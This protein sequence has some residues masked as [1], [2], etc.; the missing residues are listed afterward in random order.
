[1]KNIF[2]MMFVASAFIGCS[3]TTNRCENGELSQAECCASDSKY[4]GN[5]AGTDTATDAGADVEVDTAPDADATCVPACTTGV[6]DTNTKTCVG[7]AGDGDCSAAKPF[8]DPNANM[9]VGCVD[10]G[11]CS[12][13]TSVCDTT[14]KTCV[15]CVGAQGCAA[16]EV[17][18]P[19][20]TCV[21]CLG[22][23]DC[24]GDVCDMA[25]NTC[26]SCL[27]DND[28]TDGVCEPGVTSATN[29]CVACRD[30]TTCTTV[31][32]SKCEVG[33]NE[34]VAC[35]DVADC[36]H[37]PNATKYCD[38]GLCAGCHLK[39]EAVDCGQF[40]CDGSTNA[41]SSTMAGNA[42]TCAPCTANADCAIGYR[43]VPTDFGGSS[44]GNYCVQL[45]DGTTCPSPYN[46][47]ESIRVDA[48]GSSV[49]VCMITESIISCA[50]ITQYGEIC[51]TS[52]ATCDA[53][54]G[55]VCKQFGGATRA[56]TYECSTNSD[57]PNG[58]TC[59]SIAGGKFCGATGP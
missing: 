47:I 6:C 59:K 25:T 26:V 3:D 29:E 12:G 36:S 43:C 18:S 7:C 16:N 30:N 28:C 49:D 4:C 39:S 13:D 11:N 21:G 55:S 38:A 52:P 5:D 24:D 41:C 48:S 46:I 57:C 45:Y 10:N 50:A 19:T 33:T 23:G 9:C 56:C 1:M 40:F 58:I 27:G 42:G 22:D 15:A 2:L 54:L 51:T 31:A 8:C 20:N 14:T 44:A 37:I 34:C 35:G 32:A 53:S 17:C